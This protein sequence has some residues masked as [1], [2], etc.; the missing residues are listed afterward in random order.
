MEREGQV[1]RQPEGQRQ[2]GTPPE[3]REYQST[4]KQLS[5]EDRIRGTREGVWPEG[6][7][8]V[9]VDLYTKS[10]A[11]DRLLWGI[12][13]AP[14]TEEI[15]QIRARTPED[16]IRL[17]S[18]REESHRKHLATRVSE[19]ATTSLSA[20]ELQAK[21]DEMFPGGL[22]QEVEGV[23]GRLNPVESQV[24]RQRFG[25][26]DGRVRTQREIGEQIGRSPRTVGRI[27]HRALTKLRTPSPQNQ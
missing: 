26:E 22:Q 25:L 15:E 8:Q 20:E 24:L 7:S 18:E 21:Y 5:L 6:T 2:G 1:G 17:Q 4:Y 3:W 9:F 11:E 19:P 12:F 27:E 16:L 10:T 13:G 23:L 14:S